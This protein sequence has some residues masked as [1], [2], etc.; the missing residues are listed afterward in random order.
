MKIINKITSLGSPTSIALGFFDGVHLGH[1]KVITSAINY[2]KENDL[3]SVVLTFDKS[4]S[5]FL[6]LPEKELITENQEK[7][8][9][10][11]QLGID[12]TYLL[13]FEELI[14]LSP[15]DFVKK[16]LIK[17]LNVKHIFCGF[18][19][20]FGKDG[21]GTCEDLA[22]ICDESGI[23]LTIVAPVSY[24]GEIISSS[25]IRVS[26][27]K[28]DI[29][30]ANAMLGHPAAI[31]A[32]VNTGR[33]LGKHLGFPTVN[34]NMSKSHVLP[35]FGVYA[36]VLVYKDKKYPAI[37]NIGIKPTVGAD[38]PVAET[39]AFD[40]DLGSLYNKRVLVQLIDFVRMEKK[41]SNLDELKDNVL[42]DTEKVKKMFKEKYYQYI[43]D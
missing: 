16:I 35:L 29:I 14:D 24:D 11:E 26:L 9:L 7:C 36:S 18:N 20:R 4:P 1:Q 41:F 39:W 15:E 40:A 25:R 30:S 10:F 12:A 23:G 28:G 21:K 8:E 33:K 32:R 34:Q 31:D 38:N 27:E 22:R 17:T 3:K 43:E 19:Y 13:P 37:T 42:S 6:N 5:I 2:A